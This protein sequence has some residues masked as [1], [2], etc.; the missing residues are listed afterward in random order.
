MHAHT[1]LAPFITT[2]CSAVGSTHSMPL[3]EQRKKYTFLQFL[4]HFLVFYITV[5]SADNSFSPIIVAFN[6]KN[7]CTCNESS[8]TEQAIELTEKGGGDKLTTKDGTSVQSN[9]ALSISKVVP[10]IISRS[11]TLRI[12]LTC[13]PYN[14]VWHYN[15]Q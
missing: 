6:N 11:P 9:V 3:L 1:I 12:L 13:P 5:S 2:S 8:P 10:C 15:Y 7:P 14:Y 4:C